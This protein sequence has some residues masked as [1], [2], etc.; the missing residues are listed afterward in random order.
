MLAF[1]PV[2]FSPVCTDQ[3]S[4]YQEVL[5]EI[6]ERGAT[7]AGVSVDS[8][9][10]HTAFREKLGLTIPLL[11]DFHPKGEVCDAY[12]AYIPERGH[13][14][15]SLVLVDEDGEVALVARRADAARDPR[16]EPDL[17]R[18]RRR[19]PWDVA[20]PVAAEHVAGQRT[21]ARAGGRDHVRG[22][23]RRG[24][25][26]PRPRLP[27]LRGDL[28]GDRR[29]AAAALRAPLPDEGQAPALAR[30]H[31]A[32]E[33]AALQS[34]EAFWGFWD[35]L[36]ADRAH[37]DD[38]HLWERAER[39]GLDLERFERDRRSRRGRRAGPP[40]LRQRDPRRRDRDA[41]RRSPPPG[42]LRGDLARA[43]R[44]AGGGGLVRGLLGAGGRAACSRWLA[45]PPARARELPPGFEDEVVYE[46]LKSPTSVSFA[47]DGRAFVTEKNGMVL[48]F[49]GR[50][51]TKP[52]VVADLRRAVHSFNE[53]GLMSGVLDPAFPRRPYL[54][55]G[56]TYNAPLGGVAPTW[57][58]SKAGKRK[59]GPEGC[60]GGRPDL[61]FAVRL[62]GQQ[63]GLAPDARQGRTGEGRG[64][65]AR[66]LVPAVLQPLDRRSRLRPQRRAARR[67]R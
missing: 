67:R 9:F 2:D 3:L 52:K 34:E 38:P 15:R 33:A 23:G 25:R 44:R 6:E 17:R 53:R 29:A 21:A 60:L 8:A 59:G 30:L 32:S 28:G 7:L 39:F 13:A 64:R 10:C 19:G 16:R 4:I 50:G 57:G 63:P 35:S 18:A 45:A 14:N 61:G 27:A 1:Y 43:A 65:A 56:Y 42:P 24:D 49:D 36:L 58:L 5:G 41:V 66:G 46:G 37:V 62:P 55:V 40:R 47:P 22:D 11:A 31:A 48:A 12:G 26:L 54:Y 51:D 20:V